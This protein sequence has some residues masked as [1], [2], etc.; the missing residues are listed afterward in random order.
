MRILITLLF[1]YVSLVIFSLWNSFPLYIK[2][3]SIPLFLFSLYKL[4]IDLNENTKN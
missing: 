3:V 4:Y 2:V 1:I